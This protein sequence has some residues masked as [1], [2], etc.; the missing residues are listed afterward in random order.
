MTKRVPTSLQF[1]RRLKW[2][3]GTP[4]IDQIEP[5]R[6]RLFSEA[7]DARDERGQPR[8]NLVLRSV[9]KKNWKSV[10]LILAALYRLFAWVSRGGNQCY[11]LCNDEDQA[12]DNLEIGSKIIRANPILHDA[13]RLLKDGIVRKDGRG[14]LRILPAKDIAGAHG[15]TFVFVGFDEIHE[16]RDWSLLEAMQL[17]PTRPDA[18][19][20]ITSYAS[21]HHR[22]GTPLYDLF[23]RGKAGSDPRML[24]TWYAAD[25][26]TDP[27][28]ADATP[29]DRA[30]PS[31]GSWQDADYLEQQRRRL[32]TVRFRRLHLN[33][34]GYPDG[35]ALDATKLDAA[36]AQGVRVRPPEPGIH[37]RAFADLSHGSSDDAALAIGHLDGSRR[38][39]DGVWTQ[40]GRPP[41]DPKKVIPRFAA[42]L[43]VYRISTVMADTFGTKAPG[44][45]FA[46]DWQAAG[47]TYRP[48]PLTKPQLYEH[49]E[50]AL[51]S[52][53]VVLPDDP[54]TLEQLAGLQVRAG[55]IE[56][57]SGERD[58]KANS[59]AGVVWCLGA[60]AGRPLSQIMAEIHVGPRREA[61][62]LVGSGPRHGRDVWIAAGSRRR[63]SSDPRMTAFDEG[64]RTVDE[65]PWLTE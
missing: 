27:A 18:M 26:T 29:E 36:V 43:R 23:Q 59:I 4:L 28:Y 20:W 22:P 6:R 54:V 15:K 40:L 62:G 51:N 48:S 1:F 46:A 61:G 52:G 2:L 55:R 14:F 30:N 21:L 25:F 60:G 53:E 63:E 41:F 65:A 32:P 11:A 45:T 37:Y 57:R 10:D 9:S 24:F 64:R 39:I 13:C 47:I 31:R 42:I 44:L 58:D 5:Y 35:G 16:Y 33:L 50:V 7:L 17:D 38:V 49:L 3:D 56:K 12:G 34:P 8:Y 19:M